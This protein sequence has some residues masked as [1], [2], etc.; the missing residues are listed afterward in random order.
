MTIKASDLSWKEKT[1]TLESLIFVTKKRNRAIKVRK[2]MDRNNQH[3]YNGYAK[4]D[5]SSLTMV[6]EINER[7]RRCKRED[8]SGCTRHSER[9]LT[10]S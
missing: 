9:L 6:T 1:K 4:A 3:M 5:G 8:I 7:G 10:S 2:V